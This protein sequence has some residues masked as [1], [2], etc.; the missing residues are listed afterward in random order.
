MLTSLQITVQCYLYLHIDQAF[1]LRESL[2]YTSVKEMSEMS[3]KRST[4]IEPFEGPCRCLV[5]QVKSRIW[6]AGS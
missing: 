4:L 5:L 2:D 6:T 1:Q 3:S